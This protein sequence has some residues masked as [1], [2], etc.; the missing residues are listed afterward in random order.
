[1]MPWM[2][3]VD[4]DSYLEL[5]KA[6]DRDR[7]AVHLDIVNTINS[8][9]K[10][11]TTQNIIKSCFAKLGKYI[12]SVHVKDI[13]MSQDMTVHLSEIIAGKG[14][15]DH[16]CLIGEIRKTDENIPLMLE[17]LG[18]KEEYTEAGDYIKSLF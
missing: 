6:V 13:F 10:Y 5:I 8:P 17:H 18:T 16:K 2:Y 1:M 3:P 7:F 15:F 12:K 9:V 11:Y 4:E 14:N